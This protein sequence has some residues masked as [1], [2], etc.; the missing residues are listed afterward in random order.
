M[1][2]ITLP[3][4]ALIAGTRAALGAGIALLLGSRLDGPADEPSGGPWWPLVRSA[5]SLW[6]PKW[7]LAETRHRHSR[8]VAMLEPPR[9]RSSLNDAGAVTE[10]ILKR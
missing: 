7:P 8:M 3:E 1:K 5:R 6:P 4:L 9:V 2:T 10:D